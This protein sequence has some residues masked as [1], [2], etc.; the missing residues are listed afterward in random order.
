MLEKKKPTPKKYS[1]KELPTSTTDQVRAPY[2]K[3]NPKKKIT[4]ELERGVKAVEG[5]AKSR[6]EAK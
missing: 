6:E 2:R 1:T 3:I 4:P 5:K